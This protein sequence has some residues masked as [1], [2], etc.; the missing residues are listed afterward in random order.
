MPKCC[1]FHS[2]D[3][4]LGKF[5]NK[6]R[7]FVSGDLSSGLEVR[8]I[9]NDSV[10]FALGNDT[11]KFKF[12]HLFGRHHYLNFLNCFSLIL[13]TFEVKA[14]KILASAKDFK[15]GAFRGEWKVV[16]QLDCFLDCYNSNPSSLRASIDSFTAK[17]PEKVQDTLFV[18]GDM[19]ELGDLSDKYHE[20]AGAYFRE[21]SLEN[22]VFIGERAKPFEKGFCKEIKHFKKVEDVTASQLELGN[23]STLYLKGSRGVQLEKLLKIFNK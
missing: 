3:K 15:L 5:D 16:N 8:T 7:C 22:V 20:E 2:K 4:Y 19:Y 21:L 10:E 12:N 14:E 9:S 13:K 18:I 1:F 11:Y 6:D 17:Y 23:I